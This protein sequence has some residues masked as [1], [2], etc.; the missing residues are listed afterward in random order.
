[1]RFAAVDLADSRLQVFDQI[2]ER[3]CKR[4]VA[5]DQ[6]IVSAPDPI[7]G[8]DRPGNLAKPPFCPVATDSIPDLLG[9]GE[10]DA[11]C[12]VFMN[13]GRAGLHLQDKPGRRP[14]APPRQAQEI[15]SHSQARDDD[16]DAG[17]NEACLLGRQLLAAVCAAVRQHLAAAGRRFARA[18]A[19]AALSYDLAWL[20]SALRRHGLRPWIGRLWRPAEASAEAGV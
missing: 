20:I 16:F 4:A 2:R 19:V 5:A 6:N 1:V 11:D 17:G 8:E 18:K 12:V 14:L 7:K 10:A 3:P 9:D 15:G 13:L